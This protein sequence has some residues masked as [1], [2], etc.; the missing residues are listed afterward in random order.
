M[1]LKDRF[2]LL[3]GKECDNPTFDFFKPFVERLI[4]G[5]HVSVNTD[6]QTDLAVNEAGD[7]AFHAERR[8]RAIFCEE[9]QGLLVAVYPGQSA[10]EKLAK[11]E[12]LYKVFETRSWTAIESMDSQRLK[13]GLDALPAAVGDYKAGQ[14]A[15]KVEPPAP[16]KSDADKVVEHFGGDKGNGGENKPAKAGKVGA[17]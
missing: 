1:F 11:V 10:Q 17:R 9:I 12:I 15:P 6:R 8:Q 7:A 16:E 3:D 13:I 5:Q 14:A 2:G 4:P